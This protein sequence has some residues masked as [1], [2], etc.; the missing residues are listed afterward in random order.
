MLALDVM[1]QVVQTTAPLVHL[2][3]FYDADPEAW[4]KSVGRYLAEG[5]KQGEAALVIATPE[6]RKTTCGTG[7]RQNRPAVSRADTRAGP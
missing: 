7:Y 5:L 6:H 4:A 1:P 2:V 3:Q